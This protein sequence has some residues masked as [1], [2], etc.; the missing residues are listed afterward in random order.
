MT[1]F[2]EDLLTAILDC[3]YADVYLMEHCQYDIG[4]IVEECIETYGKLEIN[5]LVRIMF[6]YGLRDIED[7]IR[8]RLS[9]FDDI[10][11]SEGELDEEEIKERDALES[12]D[13]FE[14]IESFHNF[15]DTHIWVDGDEK[16]KIY[17]MYLKE[18][19]DNFE[20]MTGFEI[21]LE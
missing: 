20:E 14:D 8:D 18:A 4:E 1:D 11:E 16:K 15:I 3:G 7:A 10:V 17:G 5:A 13:P 2:R 6:D 21:S 9:E 12:L 19:L